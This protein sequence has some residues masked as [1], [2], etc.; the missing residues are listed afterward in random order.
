VGVPPAGLLTGFDYPRGPRSYPRSV[1]PS[2]P[3]NRPKV[4]RS[5]LKDAG[6]GSNP[7]S[8]VPRQG[9]NRFKRGMP[10]PSDAEQAQRMLEVFT[11]VGARK[12][13]VTKLDVNQEIIWGKSYSAVELH[14][15]I[16]A[17]VHKA[18]KRRLYVLPGGR[19][20]EAAENLIVRPCCPEV[21]F[22]QLDDLNAE[23]LDRARPALTN[24]SGIGAGA[25]GSPSSPR[26]QNADISFTR[27]MS[28][29]PFPARHQSPTKCSPRPSPP[30]WEKS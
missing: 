23:Q 30:T 11:S 17:M 27:R 19:L 22:V 24:S 16:P 10:M 29:R 25:S 4:H 8:R 3:R 5:L 26:F 20:V 18:E 6:N 7:F 28:A 13:F 15:K 21:F 1:R 9:E 12:F 14:D 2:I